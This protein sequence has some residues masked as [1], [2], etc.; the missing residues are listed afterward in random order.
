MNNSLFSLMSEEDLAK[1]EVKKEDGKATKKVG[2]K[3]STTGKATTKEVAKT[4][5][6]NEKLKKECQNFTKLVVKVW[7]NEIIT[8][9]NADEIKNIDFEA[10]STKLTHEYGFEEFGE[11]K[12]ITWHVVA[13]IDK[14]TGY[15][16]PTPKFHSK[17]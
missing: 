10:L 7:G 16:I 4:L 6:P 17:G 15:L 14:L 13:S 12:D 1:I 3:K 2:T 9:T 5:S 8:I 11:N